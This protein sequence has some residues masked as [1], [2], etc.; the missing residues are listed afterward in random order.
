MVILVGLAIDQIAQSGLSSLSVIY[1]SAQLFSRFLSG[2]ILFSTKYLSVLTGTRLKARTQRSTL[3]VNITRWFYSGTPDFPGITISCPHR[4]TLYRV[5][6]RNRLAVP[7]AAFPT[8]PTP[9]AVTHS[10][11]IGDSR[12]PLRNLSCSLPG[13]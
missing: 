9:V 8:S 13:C 6:H 10:A 2:F 3:K 1:Y 5:I 11:S 12:S 7:S 4:K